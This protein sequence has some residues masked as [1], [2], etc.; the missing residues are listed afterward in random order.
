M[1]TPNMRLAR[2]A[3]LRAL[4]DEAQPIEV[5]VRAAQDRDEPRARGSRCAP[6]TP[7]GPATASA[8]AG[9]MIDRVSSK[10]SLIAAQI[11]S[12]DTRTISSTVACTIGNVSSP[13]SRT[14]TPSAKMP[15]RS[16]VIAPPGLERLVHRVG[17]VRFDADDA[18]VRA[19]RLDVAGDARR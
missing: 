9:S 18:D 1:V 5:H 14:A 15:T 16:S 19:Q 7:A 11:S 8:P 3:D 4:G 10:T 17:L 13:T 12:F 6:P 2:F